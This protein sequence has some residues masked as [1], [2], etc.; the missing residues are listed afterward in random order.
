MAHFFVADITRHLGDSSNLVN[1]ILTQVSSYGDVGVEWYV[2]SDQRP[3]LPANSSVFVESHDEDLAK[4]LE[5]RLVSLSQ[6]GAAG[7]IFHVF[8]YDRFVLGAASALNGPNLC[9]VTHH[10]GGIRA[11]GQGPQPLGL[12]PPHSFEVRLDMPEAMLLA[13]RVLKQGQH[14]SRESAL[15]QKDLRP[16]MAR[17]DVRALKNAADPLSNSLITHVVRTGL[18]EG[19]LARESRGY[20]Q[21][22]YEYIWLVEEGQKSFRPSAPIPPIDNPAAPVVDVSLSH[23]NVPEPLVI[24]PAESETGPRVQADASGELVSPP[25]P[26]LT[27][28]VKHSDKR[29]SKY[30]V[31]PSKQMED[32][33][34]E[35]HIGTHPK[36]RKLLFDSF[37]NVL[38]GT[39]E[40]FP[41]PK[42]RADA[43]AAAIV[44][45]G[46]IYT[47]KDWKTASRCFLSM[48][49]GGGALI[50]RDGQRISKGP[51]ALAAIAIALDENYR[52]RAE[53]FLIEC[54]IRARS[55]LRDS[56]AFSAGLAL[57][58]TGAV[59]PTPDYEIE[60]FVAQILELLLNECRIKFDG[61]RYVVN[62]DGSP[63]TA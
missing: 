35:L 15:H 5:G 29:S 36:T 42:L 8:S 49:I 9:V 37:K 19:W 38:A 55:G 18:N 40:G 45:A 57:Y 1:A 2:R 30:S 52:L 17:I 28:E 62:D 32:I 46:S 39:H 10:L 6:N 7:S 44:A 54:I 41:L 23:L 34:R 14:T 61:E 51:R 4:R 21:T 47:D 58:Q 20:G 27:Y 3:H 31:S 24:R 11:I 26:D 22:G 48:M 60:T 25:A 56:E 53:A 12:R 59:D 13:K 16:R 43:L 50:G 33:L 63:G